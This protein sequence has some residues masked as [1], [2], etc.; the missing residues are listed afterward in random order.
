[1]QHQVFKT[2]DL[3]LPATPKPSPPTRGT[4]QL[5]LRDMVQKA[6]IVFITAK[7]RRQSTSKAIITNGSSNSK[8]LTCL[9]VPFLRA[10]STVWLLGDWKRNLVML[11][12]ITIHQSTKLGD[13]AGHYNPPEYEW[14]LKASDH[15]EKLRKH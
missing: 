15:Q 6:I 9:A 5:N 8:V 3:A 12:A 7:S 4:N 1:M 2:L 10:F 11:L 14:E 13:A